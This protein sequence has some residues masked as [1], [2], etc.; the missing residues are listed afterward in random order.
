MSAISGIFL[1][2]GSAIDPEQMKRMNKALDHR[3]PDGSVI[4]TE[5]S[6]GLGHQMF[7]TTPESLNEKLPYVEEDLVI[8]ADARIDNREELSVELGI[9]DKESISDSYFI[10]KSYQKWGEQCP[11]KLLGDFV[12]AIWDK[13]KEELFCARDHMGIKPFYYYLSD[14]KFIFATEV[15]AIIE[16]LEF[17][18][19]VN[20]KMIA[21]ILV[22]IFDDK[23]D[24]F[25]EDI[26]RLHPGHS[27]TVNL[28]EHK[29]EEYWS[30]NPNL[31][32]RLNSDD[33]YQERF[34]EIFTECIRCRLRT[35]YPVGFE[36]SG[37][38]DSSSVVS[39]ASKINEEEKDNKLELSTY[40]SLFYKPKADESFYAKS[41]VKDRKIK[42]N[43]IV[44]DELH[45]LEDI[46]QIIWHT[47]EPYVPFN[48]Y[49]SWKIYSK[50]QKDGNRIILNGVYGDNVLCV[51]FPYLP[52][53]FRKFKWIKF[54]KEFSIYNKRFQ[55]G[56]INGFLASAVYPMIPR[57]VKNVVSKRTSE[58]SME[59]I[60]F[61]EN[62]FAVKTGIKNILKDFFENE[63]KIAYNLNNSHYRSLVDGI[64]PFITE[65]DYNLSA[66]FSLEMRYPYLDKRLVE[67]C[68]SLPPEIK[69][70]DGWD[71]Y[72]LRSSLE[73]ILPEEVRWRDTKTN[74][75]NNFYENLFK[76][77][78]DKIRGIIKD[79]QKKLDEIV[80]M[81]NI[82]QLI[83]GF[84]A[85]DL[86]DGYKKYQFNQIMAIWMV[87]ILALW[88]D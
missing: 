44:G 78:K 37:G 72:I 8:T 84:E 52:E 7:Y 63:Q 12:F 16:I 42:A 15:K 13:G 65:F 34:L 61:D 20:K 87:I 68:Y 58:K 75:A 18:P 45:P 71:K 77:E 59:E 67:F 81:D 83:D 14:D 64:I 10:L 85:G 54:A 11:D 51:P 50:A 40:H 26:F 62:E 19:G 69:I 27:L 60:L 17:K 9:E 30:L 74:Y 1:R 6:L 70:K 36:L 76:F 21:Q 41:V 22:L 25:Y 3:G 56:Y 57:F 73:G 39:V 79:N 4:W 82:N 66:A 35:V 47:D 86:Y 32:L 24:T 46:E 31:R 38:L 2:N 49:I 53:L 33:E 48:N 23:T 5:D 88:L 43:Y 80:K 55:K 29:I 28:K